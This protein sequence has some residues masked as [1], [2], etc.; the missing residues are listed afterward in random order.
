MIV[1]VG[2]SGLLGRQ[3]VDTLTARGEQVRVVVRD[4]SRAR[5][6]LGEH[7]EVHVADVLQK[8]GLDELLVGASVV[9]SA[10]HGFL[11]GR[12]AGPQEVD[13]RGNR[14]LVDAA[15][16]AGASV[17]LVSLIGAAADSD[18]EL[19]RAKHAAEEHLRASGTPWTIVRSGP[20][21]ETWLAVLAQTAGASGRPLVFGRGER[22]LAFVSATDV[23]YVVSRAVLDA[24]LRGQV[25]EVAGAP[26]TMIELAH[27][28]QACRGWQ[29]DVRHVPR[30]VLRALS[31]LT[32]PVAPAFARK[33][34]A[35][36][37]MDTGAGAA[38]TGGAE[39]LDRPP[40]Q[41]GDVL[42]RPLPMLS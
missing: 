36:L 14:H 12:R 38:L 1:V 5:G 30:P 42:L 16:R 10:F 35:A 26:L 37:A 9:V 39:L 6:A 15:Q 21:L 25:L 40:L 13:V 31:M 2:G 32:R 3:V 23:A 33:N 18:L 24:T 29:G 11:G 8:K 41:V 4:G 22:R 34:R 7:V 19:G 28:L 17:V 20:F 27:A